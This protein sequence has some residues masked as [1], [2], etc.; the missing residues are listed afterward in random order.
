MAICATVRARLEV[1]Q[2]ER[3]PCCEANCHASHGKRAS[4]FAVC[5]VAVRL[6]TG[7]VVARRAL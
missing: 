6:P 4:R 1:L 7:E 2:P 3:R 5:R